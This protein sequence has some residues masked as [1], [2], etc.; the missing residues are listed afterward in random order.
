MILFTNHGTIT[1]SIVCINK[2]ISKNLHL[3]LLHDKNN[4]S[5]F[6]CQIGFMRNS[7]ALMLLLLHLQALTAAYCTAQTT[8]CGN[9]KNLS[10]A[11][12]LREIDTS[13]NIILTALSLENTIT[14]N[15]THLQELVSRK[16]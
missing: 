8:Q 6:F 12:I 5:R 9:L 15:C 11:Q 16:I 7:Y 4:F 3:P 1:Q 10:A 14:E 2:I 13:K